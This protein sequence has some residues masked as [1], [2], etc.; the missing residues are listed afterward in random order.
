M[1]IKD[2]MSYNVITIPS[3]TSITEAKRI[4]AAHHIRR[5]PVVDKGK[6]VGIVT[7]RSVEHVSPSKLTSLSVGELNYLLDST[8]V[9]EIMTKEVVTVMPD[10]DAEEAV[11]IA[12][13]H[14]VGSVVVAEDNKIVGIATTNDLFYKIINPLLGINIPGNRIEITNGI[15]TGKGYRQL[16][17]IISIIHEFGFKIITLHIEGPP[18]KGI[19]DVCFH[20]NDGDVTKLNKE[21]ENQGYKVRIRSR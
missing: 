17:K 10:T 7:E 13:K 14:K 20:L 6:L 15:V 18:E 9:K 4:M 2:L 21:L 5:L 16:E 11:A 12:Q 1:K 19:R 8:L 3:D